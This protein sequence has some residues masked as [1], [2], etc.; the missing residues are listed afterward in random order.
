MDQF[1]KWNPSG[2]AHATRSRID[3]LLHIWH[4]LPTL[5]RMV[6]RCLPQA[7]HELRNVFRCFSRHP[8]VQ[9]QFANKIRYHS[10]PRTGVCQPLQRYGRLADESQLLF[11][12]SYAQ[13][14]IWMRYPLDPCWCQHPD[15]QRHLYP[16]STWSKTSILKLISSRY[17]SNQARVQGALPSRIVTQDWQVS[18]VAPTGNPWFNGVHQ[19]IQTTSCQHKQC[20]KHSEAVWRWSSMFPLHWFYEGI[21][22][23][24]KEHTQIL[25][26]GQGVRDREK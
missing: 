2:L 12:S 17:T 25:K 4:V 9:T 23:L 20:G 19:T 16:Y 22:K 7:T 13:S 14:C 11:P 18:S 1:Q 24:R 3:A 15:S 21:P 26:G 8:S 10:D 5:E 6:R